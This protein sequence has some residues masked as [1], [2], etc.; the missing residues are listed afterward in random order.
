M[1]EPL[2]I[3]RSNQFKRDYKKAK[4]QGK[5]LPLFE[6]SFFNLIRDPRI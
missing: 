1:I 2:K 6:L 4:K 3:E 5:D